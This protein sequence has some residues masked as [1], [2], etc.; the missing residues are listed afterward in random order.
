MNQKSK[1]ASA[2]FAFLLGGVGVHDFY[3]GYTAKGIMHVAMYIIGV[4]LA[5]FGI[6]PYIGWLI[7]LLGVILAIGNSVWAIIEGIM[8]CAKRDF[9]DVHGNTLR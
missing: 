8:I 5:C 4:F 3:L 9:H 1:L 2:L 6:I 7:A